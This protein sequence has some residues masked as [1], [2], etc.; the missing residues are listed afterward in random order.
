MRVIS[1]DT[2]IEKGEYRDIPAVLSIGVFDGVH[3]GHK[4]ILNTLMDMKNELSAQL[5]AV[6]T[7]STNPKGKRV[8]LDTPRLREEYIASFGVDVLVVIDFSPVFSKISACEFTKL[9]RRSILPVGAV[10]GEDF[11]FGNPSSSGDGHALGEYLRAL[12]VDSEIKIVDSVMDDGGERISSTRLRL[13]IEKGDLGCFPSLSGQFYRVDLVPLPYRS[14]S[15][16]LIFSR[17]SIHQLL[18]PPGL[19]DAVLAFS[20]GRKAECTASIEDDVLRILPDQKDMN[21]KDE[22]LLD[23]LYLEKRR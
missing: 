14:G 21:G 23:S 3:N 1:F 15:G 13:M 18:P 7:F 4:A 12:G 22:L 20:D 11:R 2:F 5:S 17:A 10:V 8:C 6:I 9:L 19:Y 16:E